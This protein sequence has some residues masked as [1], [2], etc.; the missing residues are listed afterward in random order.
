[1]AAFFVRVTMAGSATAQETLGFTIDPT[2]GIPGITVS[3]QVN[4]DDIAAHCTTDLAA[5]EAEF[6][7]VLEGPYAGGLNSGELFSR[8]FPTGEFVFDTCD[9]A[10]YSLT[11][12]T[13]L[14]I[15]VEYPGCR[16]DRAATDVRDD[17]HRPRHPESY[18]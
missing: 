3:G 6:Q 2:Q 13:V 4:P 15:G 7:A 11:G 16:R 10:A 12:I 17:L 18:R 14:A 5:F 9:Q 8:F 1:M